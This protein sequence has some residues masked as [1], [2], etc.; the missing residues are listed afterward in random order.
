MYGEIF[1]YGWEF[2]F[3]CDWFLLG[4]S[5]IIGVYLEETWQDRCH[6]QFDSANFN[7][8]PTKSWITDRFLECKCA[9][10]LSFPAA[11]H[12]SAERGRWEVMEI[13]LNNGCDVMATDLHGN[14]ALHYCGHLETVECL[15]QYGCNVNH[16]SVSLILRGGFRGSDYSL[17]YWKTSVY[18]PEDLGNCLHIKYFGFLQSTNKNWVPLQ[19]LSWFGKYRD[20]HLET[21]TPMTTE[22]SLLKP[23]NLAQLVALL[24]YCAT[25]D[26]NC[27]HIC[28]GCIAIPG[29]LNFNS[30]I[31]K[32]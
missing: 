31:C 21:F 14:T 26:V 18:R 7:F 9:T 5:F 1:H 27:F 17:Q 22:S 25:A 15:I 19:S 28:A 23:V 4:K 10:L 20:S 11:L 29:L 30:K 16:R 24:L 2:E 6:F 8:V 32:W 3:Q 13:L 12:V